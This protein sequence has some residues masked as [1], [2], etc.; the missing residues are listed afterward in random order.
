MAYRSNRQWLVICAVLLSLA[1]LLAIDLYRR[2]EEVSQQEQQRLVSLASAINVNMAEQLRASSRMLDGL[3]GS[4]P[5]LLMAP[6][7]LQHLNQRMALLSESVIGIRSMLLVNSKGIAIASNRPELVGQDVS[8]GRRY[9]D[10][11]AG[12]DAK[13]LYV[14]QPFATP[15]S[16]YTIGLGRVRQDARGAFDGYLLAILSPDYF[17]VLMESLLYAPDMRLS[18]VHG[19]GLVVFSTLATPGIQGTDL[20]SRADS[21]FNRYKAS[22][23]TSAFA[24]DYSTAT[25]DLRYV[26]IQTVIPT[27]VATNKPLLVAVSRDAS[28]VFADWRAYMLHMCGL[29]AGTVL[30]AGLAYLGYARRKRAYQR[31]V[32]QR[33]E[34]REEALVVAKSERFVRAITDAMPEA[35]AY[36]DAKLRCSFANKA[37]LDWYQMD[38]EAMA[39]KGLKELLG[40]SLF[41]KNQP[42][43]EGALGGQAQQFE[44]YLTKRDGSVGHVLANYIPDINEQGQ[45]AGFVL[46]VTD[47]K[48]V[49]LAEADR[50][51]AASVF[52]NTADGIMVTDEDGVILSVNPAFTVITGYLAQ[53]AIGQT[54]R[55]LR[56]HHH[57]REFFASIWKQISEQGAWKGEIWNRR[58]NGEIFLMWQAITRVGNAPDATGRYISVFH[59]VTDAWYKNQKTRQLAFH[60]ALTGL[61]NRALLM[62]RLERNILLNG[63]RPQS[64]AVLFLDLD[65]F[66]QVNDTHG[67][68]AGDELLQDIGRLLQGLVRQTDT[69]ARLGGDE[70]VVLLDNPAGQEEVL[71]IADRA[72]AALR[73]PVELAGIVVTV[74]ASIG[75]ALFPEHGRTSSELLQSADEA[76]YQAKRDGKNTYRLAVP[77][78]AQDSMRA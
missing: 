67:H 25:H 61:A 6:D 52:E 41:A 20:S 12:N 37:Y 40:E 14:S 44:R 43:I 35:V 7:G 68:A 39:G 2:H 49:R 74:G 71:Q 32:V 23:Q 8:S 33:D 46:L 16:T 59:D 27:G 24:V 18:V 19:D 58:K 3:A 13:T 34:V 22:G 11:R 50:K 73:Q 51:V 72:I 30:V 65:G 56:S 36:F 77:V 78:S 1:G 55:L 64:L 15:L 76:M 45:V 31:V 66:K 62:E 5:S 26:A 21:F 17:G 9:A 60:D 57:E 63:R 53:D 10:M 48:A 69:V 75:I 4:V 54:P 38:A 47:I 29:Y 28:A 70:F 42:H